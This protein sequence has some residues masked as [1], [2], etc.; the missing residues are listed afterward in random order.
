MKL[1]ERLFG[2]TLHLFL[3]VSWV[4]G[5]WLQ[6][7]GDFE[8]GMMIVILTLVVEL[9]REV[10]RVRKVRRMGWLKIA[11]WGA[12]AV[13]SLLMLILTAF[14]AVVF[15]GRT[16]YVLLFNSALSSVV[17]LFGSAVMFWRNLR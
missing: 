12:G 10:W 13:L 15:G 7:Y 2:V 3:F 11:G 1:L 9:I 6:L 16:W 8:A 14:I 17:F 4:L 5:V